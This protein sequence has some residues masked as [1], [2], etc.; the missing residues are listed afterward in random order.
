MTV[1]VRFAGVPARP[2]SGDRHAVVGT[3]AAGSTS[4]RVADAAA[5]RPAA[6]STIAVVGLRQGD[7]GPGVQAVQQKLISFG[8][9]VADGD[10]GHSGAGMTAASARS[11]GR[12]DSTR[13]A[14]SPRTRRS[15]S[16]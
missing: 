14:S 13:P 7:T 10:D 11:S 4:R 3:L 16:V 2:P 12:T 6:E 15:T 8:Y 9:Y 1:N 5:R